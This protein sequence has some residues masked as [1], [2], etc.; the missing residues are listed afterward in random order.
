[1]A[2]TVTQENAHIHAARS[3]MMATVSF[4]LAVA[5]GYS[6]TFL[7]LSNLSYGAEQMYA[8]LGVGILLNCYFV[9]VSVRSTV[10]YSL[11]SIT[12]RPDSSE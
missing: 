8:L 9:V 7:L 10:K 11:M 3:A 5:L 6:L 12:G 2:A 1:M 4:L